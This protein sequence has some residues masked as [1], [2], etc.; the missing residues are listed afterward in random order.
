MLLFKKKIIALQI[1]RGLDRGLGHFSR[2]QSPSPP[3]FLSGLGVDE[4]KSPL[5]LP[6]EKGGLTGEFHVLKILY[7]IDKPID[8]SIDAPL[9]SSWTTYPLAMFETKN[10]R[11]LLQLQRQYPAV[12]NRLRESMT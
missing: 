3:G 8:I 5:N 1:K 12:C 6:F 9:F 11:N 7:L 2:T 4:G 10:L